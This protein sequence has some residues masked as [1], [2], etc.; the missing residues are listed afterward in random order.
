[1]SRHPRQHFHTVAGCR[2]WDYMQIGSKDIKMQKNIAL[3]LLQSTCDGQS[4]R[5]LDTG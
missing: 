4:P 5:V 1:M 2:M 3:V